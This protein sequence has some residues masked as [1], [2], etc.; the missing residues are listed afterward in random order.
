MMISAL[1]ANGFAE[2]GIGWDKECVLYGS[3]QEWVR[4]DLRGWR[5]FDNFTTKLGNGR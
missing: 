5:K 1:T 2:W 3:V 4:A